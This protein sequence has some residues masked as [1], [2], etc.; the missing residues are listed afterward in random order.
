MRNPP[1]EAVE[2]IGGSG[3][4]AMPATPQPT[5]NIDVT[6]TFPSTG[7]GVAVD[8]SERLMANGVLAPLGCP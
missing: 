2:A 1:S 5:A 6:L 3:S 7:T 4:V 8:A